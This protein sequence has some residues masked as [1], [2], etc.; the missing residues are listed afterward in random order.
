LFYSWNQE[1]DPNVFD[2]YTQMFVRQIAE[3]RKGDDSVMEYDIASFSLL[4]KNFPF[5]DFAFQQVLER[6]NASTNPNPDN[7]MWHLKVVFLFPIEAE[8]EDEAEDE[9]ELQT[10]WPEANKNMYNKLLAFYT[11]EFTGKEEEKDHESIK[12]CITHHPSILILSYYGEKDHDLSLVRPSEV[13][14]DA[15]FCMVVAA[16]TYVVSTQT[17]TGVLIK[18]PAAMILW[19]ATNRMSAVPH[20]TTHNKMWRRNGFGLFLISLIVKRLAAQAAPAADGRLPQSTIWLWQCLNIKQVL[21][22]TM[23]S[24]YHLRGKFPGKCSKKRNKPSSGHP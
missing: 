16:V 20:L 7:S 9:D 18:E 11:S 14:D 15:P 19:L 1:D 5:S 21:S 3:N 10:D 8:N 17:K 24:Q 6:A 4:Y 13:S 23:P 22:A 12:W 2:I